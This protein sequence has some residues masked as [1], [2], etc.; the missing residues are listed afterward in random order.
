VGSFS[1]LV[2]RGLENLDLHGFFPE[3]ALEL[4]DA[5]LRGP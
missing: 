2:P 5:L 3:R 1:Y 4:F